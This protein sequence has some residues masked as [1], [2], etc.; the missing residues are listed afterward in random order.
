MDQALTHQLISTLKD[1]KPGPVALVRL[2]DDIEIPSTIAHLKKLQFP[3]V[4]VLETSPRS[5]DGAYSIKADPKVDLPTILNAS[6]DH[7]SGRW[8]HACHN[9]EYLF[10]PFCEGRSIWDA[11]QF[12]QEERRDAVFTSVIDLYPE[13]FD[14]TD[15]SLNLEAAYLDRAGYYSR[16]RYVGP[17][18][19]DRQVEVFGGLKW[20]YAEHVEWERQRIDRPAFFRA[21]T[22]LRLD[23]RS[24]FN[25]QEMNT[26][27]CPW[28]HSMTFALASFRVAKSL[29]NISGSDYSIDSFMWS[30]SQKFEWS[31]PQLMELG[32]MEPGQWF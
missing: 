32:L 2:E 19:Q 15:Q 10:F 21:K 14:R 9:S 22:G 25:D 11:A 4:I 31:S 27:S 8:I 23:E 7:L 29:I 30:Q 20:R 5:H 13:E 12:V 3:N 24:R 26:L 28:H 16:D 18:K 1:L 6:I 17:E